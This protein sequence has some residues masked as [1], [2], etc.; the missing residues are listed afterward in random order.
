M[1]IEAMKQADVTVRYDLSPAM[2]ESAIRS[3]LIELGWTP[4]KAEQDDL[5]PTHLDVRRILLDVVP[6]D[7]SGHEIYAKSVGDVKSALTKMAERIEELEDQL[8]KQQHTDPIPPGI[9]VAEITPTKRNFWP[10]SEEQNFRLAGII[11]EPKQDEP[12]AIV[13]YNE[14]GNIRFLFGPQLPDQTPL[15]T[16]PQPRTWVGLT[17]EEIDEIYLDAST[18]IEMLKEL[19]AKLKEKNNG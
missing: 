11:A 14:R 3:K 7:G 12:V 9:Y 19:E 4:P 2:T 15:Y 17:D 8:A 6:G 10:L 16:H 1:S 13:D 5:V 18:S